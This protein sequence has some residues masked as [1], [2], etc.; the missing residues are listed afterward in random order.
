MTIKIDFDEVDDH[1]EF[2]VLP[3]GEYLCEVE[4][5]EEKTGKTSGEP[6]W[7]L[8]MAVIEGEH[9]NRI[10][11]DKLFFTEGALKRTKLVFK[12]LGVDV[13]GEQ[14]YEE[15]ELVGRQAYVTAAIEQYEGKDKNVV[16]FAGYRSIED[17]EEDADEPKKETKKPSG[18]KTTGKKTSKPKPKPEPIDEEDDIPDFE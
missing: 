1:E 10:I 17:D 5:C 6:Y 16:P 2:G 4:A 7:N 3:E 14:N 9:E 15:E 13:S 11:F 12:R 8:K 18:K